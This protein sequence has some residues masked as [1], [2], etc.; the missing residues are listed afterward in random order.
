MVISV[1]LAN[2]ITYHATCVADCS[3][4]YAADISDMIPYHATDIA[5][6]IVYQYVTARKIPVNKIA[7]FLIEI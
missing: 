5:D 6:M 1:N 3:V 2:V 7:D 4:Y